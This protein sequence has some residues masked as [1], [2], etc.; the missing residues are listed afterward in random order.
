MNFNVREV[1]IAVNI[2]IQFTV[3]NKIVVTNF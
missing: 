2:N 1:R 3:M